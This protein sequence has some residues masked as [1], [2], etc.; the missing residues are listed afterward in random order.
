MSSFECVRPYQVQNF[1]KCSQTLIVM[2]PSVL[3]KNTGNK[4]EK[5]GKN[6]TFSRENSFI[7][8]KDCHDQD[9]EGRE[10]DAMQ[11]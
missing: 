7:E 4:E 6:V 10:A 1:A 3:K 8:A 9:Y 2:L 11:F 5:E